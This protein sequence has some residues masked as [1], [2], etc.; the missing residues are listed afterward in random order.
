MRAS[1]SVDRLA[2]VLYSISMNMRVNDLGFNHGSFEAYT[3]GGCRCVQCSVI[4]EHYC[5]PDGVPACIRLPG[6]HGTCT[7]H[8][9]DRV[10]DFLER[11]LWGL[12]FSSM[13]RHY[14]RDIV[15]GYQS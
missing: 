11:E 8:Q 5:S 2:L 9:K 1:L 7:G 6:H 4:P 10:L 13:H 15:R 3:T 12:N 14:T